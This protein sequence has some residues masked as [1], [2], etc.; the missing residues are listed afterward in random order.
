MK[1]SFERPLSITSPAWVPAHLPEVGEAQE[2]EL[3]LSCT[4]HGWGWSQ[5]KELGTEHFCNQEP[6]SG[7]HFL[8]PPKKE[9]KIKSLD[10]S[11]WLLPNHGVASRRGWLRV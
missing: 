1:E 4:L 6:T 10:T 7:H 9:V 3:F 8:V 5:K 2:R 11:S